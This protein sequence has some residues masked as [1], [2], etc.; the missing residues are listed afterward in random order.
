MTEKIIRK[1]VSVIVV[2]GNVAGASTASALAERGVDVMLLERRKIKQVGFGL[3][4][5][6]LAYHQ[7]RSVGMEIPEGDF[8][9]RDLTNVTVYSP[10]ETTS[11]SFDNVGKSINR[12][13]FNQHLL[14]HAR[15]SGVKIV[16]STVGISPILEDG[17]V[18]GLEVKDPIK[19]EEWIVRSDIL[20]D[21]TGVKGHIRRQLPGACPI[22]ETALLKETAICYVEVRER[23]KYKE[24]RKMDGKP[25]LN[26]FFSQELAPGGLHWM[27]S[28]FHS[29]GTYTLG[30]GV[31]NIEGRPNPKEQFYKKLLPRYPFLKGLSIVQSGGGLV[32]T[33]VPLSSLVGNGIVAV[34][35]SGYQ[36]CPMT[37]CGIAT[38][39]FASEV[40]ADVITE[41]LSKGDV[42]E[43]ALWR[44]N[45]EYYKGYGHRQALMQVLSDGV[46]EMGDQGLKELANSNI[47]NPDEISRAVNEGNGEIALMNKLKV[48]LGL[49]SHPGVIFKY[50]SL[51]MKM[52]KARKHFMK[53]PKDPR[54]L[55]KWKKKAL[56]ILYG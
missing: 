50:R 2:G 54:N 12:Y 7:F 56:E 48:G 6:A 49:M 40:A 26:G 47:V 30:V 42:S 3:F 24:E 13:D 5:D 23:G 4:G 29:R 9:T 15:A 41:A 33:R 22:S 37:G 55:S 25:F 34:G 27:A 46:R 43:T 35:D 32:A 8:I 1:R 19:E 18:V 44:Y 28:D 36:T 11:L 38:S 21:A 31:R 45:I 53:Y 16:G 51:L 52:R 10:D 20:V 17:F 39:I 14:D